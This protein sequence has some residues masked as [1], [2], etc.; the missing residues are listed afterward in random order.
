MTGPSISIIVRTLNEERYLSYLLEAIK[1]QHSDYRHEI[2]IVDSGSQDETLAIAKNFQCRILHIDK[3][4]FSFGRSL[5]IGCDAAVGRYLVIISGHCVPCHG[6][7]LQNLVSPLEQGIVEYSYGRQIGGEQ[8]NWAE[9]MIFEKYFPSHSQIPQQG[10]YCNNANSALLTKEWKHYRFNETL[11]GLEDIELA[12]RMTQDGKRV[13]YVA[14]ACVFHYHHETFF[15]IRT[16]F[17]REAI[18]LRT[19]SPEISL[20]KRDAL[21]YF[22]QGIAADM[23]AFNDRFSRVDINIIRQVIRYRL[24]QYM[25][26]LKGYKMHKEISAKMR[27]SYYYPARAHKL[28]PFQPKLMTSSEISMSTPSNPRIIALLPMKRHSARIPNKNFRD[29]NGKPLFAWI[30]DTL[31]SIKEISLVIINTDACDILEKHGLLGNDRVL[32]RNRPSHLC[33]DFVSMNRIIEDDLQNSEADIYLM[34]H[35]TNPLLSSSTIRKAIDI[36]LAKKSLGICDSLFT[37][38]RIQT[39]FYKKTGEPINHDPNNLVRTQDLEPWFEE[40]SNLYLFTKDSFKASNARIG[41]KP[42]IFVNPKGETIDIDE[43]DDWNIALSLATLLVA[44]MNKQ[45]FAK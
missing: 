2:I 6:K 4:D 29:F 1:A 36:F 9:H 39:R 19:I 43:P 40:N 25:G 5:N 35:T 24:N 37:A 26:A 18:A 8:T 13:G 23:R 22:T 30:L 7:W 33:G 38:N 17:E 3:K 14:D 41:L 27:E 11:T 42:E 45:P 12:K 20:R 44:S 32:L 16:R 34:T 21:R 28:K 31:L 10:Y 15:Q